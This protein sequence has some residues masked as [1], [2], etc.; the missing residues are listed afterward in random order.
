ML[1]VKLNDLLWLSFGAD[2][3]KNTGVGIDATVAPCLKMTHDFAVS[4]SGT[5]TKWISVKLLW[6]WLQSMNN[7][8]QHAI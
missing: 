3:A 2:A 4:F 1:I 6:A 7:L 5:R 8:K